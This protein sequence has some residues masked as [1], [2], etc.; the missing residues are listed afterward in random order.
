MTEAEFLNQLVRRTG[1]QILC[2]VSN[3]FLSAHNM[4]YDAYEYL[5]ALPPG[6]VSELHLGGFTPEPD[7]SRPGRDLLVDTHTSPI[8]DP[9]W[10]LHA[11]ALRRFGPRPTLIEWDSELPPLE[12]LLAQARRADAC[13]AD[14]A[15]ET[16]YADAR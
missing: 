13:A 16:V 7:E 11:H 2:D 15:R 10:T 1:C 14:I 3:V 4:G 5:D 12:T 9:V 8:A 6:A